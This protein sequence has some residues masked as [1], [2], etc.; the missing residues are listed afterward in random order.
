MAIT[1][2]PTDTLYA[3]TTLNLTCSIELRVEVDS[4]VSV[5]ASWTGPDGLAL[6]NM[7]INISE[8]MHVGGLT[9]ESRVVIS[10]LDNQTVDGGVY[11]CT[12]MVTVT[13][14]AEYIREAMNN[15]TIVI[16]IEGEVTVVKILG[17]QWI[18]LW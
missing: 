8:A 13:G 11:T 18:R 16:T 14:N 12:V 10:P 4:P 9:Y 7:R 3:G 17:Y 2:E 1:R 5:T 15:N 6:N